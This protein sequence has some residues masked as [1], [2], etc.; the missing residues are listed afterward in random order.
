M[1]KP[2]LVLFSFICFA[3][4]L[5]AQERPLPFIQVKNLNNKIIVSWVNDYNKPI[6]ALNVQRSYDSL[7]N[8]TTIGSVLSPQ[9]RENGFADVNFPYNKMY[10]RVFVSF[11]GGSYLIT[12]SSRPVK[13]LFTGETASGE[14][15][16]WLFSEKDSG[17]V[18]PPSKPGITYPSSTIFSAKDN[19]IIIHLKNT[20]TKKYSV[21]FFDET[22][23]FLFELTKLK[24]EYLIIEKVN[25]VHT[26]WFRFE[27]YENGR[28]IE[29]N[30]FQIVKNVKKL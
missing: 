21:K 15:Y 27:L 5:F 3:N 24:E 9:S 22:E 7:K 13:D 2:F 16:P 11:E 18:Y 20:D 30:K 12:A 10:Y 25:F 14:K 1:Y 6:T 17:I 8:Y 4:L 28:L 19:N 29:N 26:G 23:K